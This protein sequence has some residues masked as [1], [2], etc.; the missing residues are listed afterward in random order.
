[1]RKVSIT[2]SRFRLL[3]IAASIAMAY[4]SL[5]TA[6]PHRNHW[7]G[8]IHHFHDHDYPHWRDGHW[9]HGDHGGRLGWWWVAANM[10][11]LYPAPIYPYPNPY[12]PPAVVV[13]REPE[14]VAAIL[15]P[16]TVWYYCKSSRNYYPYVSVCPEGWRLVPA[17]PADLPDR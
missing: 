17:Q 4:S 5:S 6:D 10:W 8:D 12:I 11:Y 9:Y 1:M 16:E 14:P 3:A 13:E 7:R 15:P 2:N